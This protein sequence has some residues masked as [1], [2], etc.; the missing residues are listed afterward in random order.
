MKWYG[1]IGYWESVKDPD[2]PFVT[3]EKIVERNY[4]GDLNNN[5][6]RDQSSTTINDNFTINNELVIFA[7]PFVL[8]NF[9]K[10]R[11]V[12]FMNSKW[13][14]KSVRVQY[15]RMTLELGDLYSEEEE[16]ENADG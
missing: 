7:D 14:I 16:E 15:P 8:G 5:Y 10:M 3:T 13:K 6:K 2:D 1:Q 4:Y 9:H 12:T 11:Y